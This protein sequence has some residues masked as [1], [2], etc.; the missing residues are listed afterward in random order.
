M[1]RSF[2]TSR[3]S[4]AVTRF[5]AQ[6]SRANTP[7][8]KPDTEQASIL[9]KKIKVYRNQIS[10]LNKELDRLKIVLEREVVAGEVD[11]IISG[12]EKGW[13]G[14]AE[15]I[16]VLQ[17][18]LD[19]LQGLIETR[20]TAG[21][22][23]KYLLESESIERA[24]TISNSESNPEQRKSHNKPGSGRKNSDLKR[25]SA[26]L[27]S[28][29]KIFEENVKEGDVEYLTRKCSDL[30]ILR[31]AGEVEKKRLGELVLLLTSRLSILEQRTR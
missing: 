17:Q 12:E 26:G 18:T 23:E 22:T 8:S 16:L 4:S 25:A 15:Q 24:R 11:S 10:A 29:F 9:S 30:D 14:R 31:K 28:S 19:Y 13:V 27:S 20:Q 21:I 3:I 2:S 7:S 1:T 5:S 6:E